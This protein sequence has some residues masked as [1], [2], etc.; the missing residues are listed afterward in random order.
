MP[1]LLGPDLRLIRDAQRVTVTHSDPEISLFPFLLPP[2]TLCPILS[3][4]F[5]HS[6]LLSSLPTEQHEHIIIIIIIIIII[7]IIII[8]HPHILMDIFT[9]DTLDRLNSS[10]MTRK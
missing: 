3:T 8:P 6:K 1:F 9:L 5:L 10:K 4:S 2:N 7:L